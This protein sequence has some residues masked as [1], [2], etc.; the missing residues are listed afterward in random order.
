MKRVM[1]FLLIGIGVVAAMQ[2]AGFDL[3]LHLT[4][5]RMLESVGI[6]AVLFMFVAVGAGPEIKRWL[7][8]DD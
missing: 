1:V 7:N 2:P 6:A 4:G 8:N 5:E 3:Q